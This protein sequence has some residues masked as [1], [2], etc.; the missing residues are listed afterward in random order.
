MR[1]TLATLLAAATVLAAPS[2]TVETGPSPG[3]HAP[4][5]THSVWISENEIYPP[6]T[7]AKVGDSINFIFVR[8]T[9]MVAQSSY[10]AP[11][12]QLKGGFYF[13]PYF[14]D[15]PKHHSIFLEVM[16]NDP[17]WLFNGA[18]DHCHNRGV[19]G[20]INSPETA[21]MNVAGFKKA[22]MAK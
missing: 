2:P 19:V 12:V 7:V 15:G 20:A 14:I 18:E 17:I 5:A 1:F 4:A 13:G 3:F 8:G 10:D 11:C 6:N 21:E 9:D 22:A 16:N